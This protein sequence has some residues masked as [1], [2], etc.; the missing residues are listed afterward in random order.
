MIF[1]IIFAI[2]LFIDIYTF[3]GIKLLLSNSS[4]RTKKII[5][6]TFWIVTGI[7]LM[8]VFGGYSFRSTTRNVAVFNWYYYLFGAFVVIYIPKILFVIFHLTEDIIFGCV[9]TIKK[10]RK[11][12]NVLLNRGKTISRSTFL[13]KTGLILASVPFA[14]F[15]WGIAK[16][17]FN[18]KIDKVKLAFPNLP[19]AFNGLR[20]I[21]ISDIHIGSFNG[22]K[23]RVAEAIDMIN[24]QN[25]DIIFF[26]GDLVNNF[27]DELDGWLPILAK[28]KAKIGKY[29]ILGNHDYGNYYHWTSERD[30]AENLQK[31]K[32]AQAQLGF[33]MLNNQS[34]VLGK[35]GDR[36]AIIGVENWGHP[37][38]P[39]YADYDKASKNVL[40][41]PFKILL[42]HD[43]NHWE[44][45]I[46]GKTDVD[47]TLSG[48]THG[49]QFGI[50]FDGF[51]W[52]PAQYKF[53][54]WAGLYRENKQFLYVN[55]GLGYIGY[56]GRVGM[57]PEITVIE[58][59]TM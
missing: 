56:P 31:I 55:R 48:H 10:L 45:K 35:D 15:A 14:S 34:S 50:H 29:S 42:S 12:K 23:S 25:P 40:D 18:F 7:M 32:D 59:T 13:S 9:W 43:P 47:L 26:T 2:I 11:P 37:P 51:R 17:R 41:I 22:F 20:I 38:F 8:C 24:S 16:G 6:S 58:L 57:D 27:Y 39:Q 49:M 3:K 52:S 36:L 21:Q 53:P 19:K 28:M 44:A 1:L 54:R 5:Y 46:M 30:K 33:Q 4:L